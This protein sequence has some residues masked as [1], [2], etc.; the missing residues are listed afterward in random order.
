MLGDGSPPCPSR[1]SATPH[2]APPGRGTVPASTWQLA[3]LDN[4]TTLATATG[5]KL[6]AR[7]VAPNGPPTVAGRPGHPPVRPFTFQ[8]P[9]PLHLRTPPLQQRIKLLAQPNSVGRLPWSWN[10]RL[11]WKRAEEKDGKGL[12]NTCQGS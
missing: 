7:Q 4:A 8:S 6:K 5:E 12:A 1:A 10:N 9:P 11:R 3:P 2:H